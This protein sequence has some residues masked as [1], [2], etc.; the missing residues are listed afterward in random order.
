MCTLRYQRPPFGKFGGST[1]IGEVLGH[2]A[3]SKARREGEERGDTSA[4]DSM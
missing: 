4:L 3:G 2:H 1:R